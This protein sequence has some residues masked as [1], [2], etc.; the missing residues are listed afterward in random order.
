MRVKIKK[1]TKPGDQLDYSLV[2][3][4]IYGH[5]NIDSFPKDSLVKNTIKKVPRSEANIEAEGGETVL[6]PGE[7]TSNGLSQHFKVQGNRHNEGGVPLNVPDGSFVFSDTRK[8]KIKDKDTLKYFGMT[9]SSTPAKIAKKYDLN[10]YNQILND[11]DSTRIDKETAQRMITNNKA[12]LS[13]I[14]MVQEAMKGFENG[15][16][17]FA[18]NVSPDMK[19][20]GKKY[21]NGSY[22]EPYTLNP[23][24]LR[25][26]GMV[27]RG[28]HTLGTRFIEG[29]YENFVEEPK[30]K[31][32]SLNQ[33]GE[34]V[35]DIEDQL[36]NTT[37]KV[38][39]NLFLNPNPVDIS[40]GNPEDKQP[41]KKEIPKK[42]NYK[43][44]E[45]LNPNVNN[46]P[47][48][49]KDPDDF[50]KGGFKD[51]SIVGPN[52]EDFMVRVYED[53]ARVLMTKDG[54]IVNS[55]QPGSNQTTTQTR[56]QPTTPAPKPP[57]YTQSP[58]DDFLMER[59]DD[60]IKTG[61]KV[62]N[63][64]TQSRRPDGTF[65]P[66]NDFKFDYEDFKVRHGE[67]IKSLGYEPD[68][69][70]AEINNPATSE[71]ATR[72][73]QDAYNKEFEKRYGRKYFTPENGE[74]YGNDGQFG[75]ITYSAPG[76]KPKENLVPEGNPVQTPVVETEE[77]VTPE[78]DRPT[79]VNPGFDSQAQN[80]NDGWWLQD[81]AA[82]AGTMLDRV[83]TYR[84][85]RQQVTLDKVDSTFVDPTRQIAS[86]QEQ[87][88]R[89]Q[90]LAMNTADGQVARANVL[91]NSG[92]ALGATADAIANYENQNAQI[93]NQTSA[94]NAEITNQERM[95]NLELDDRYIT[96][97]ATMNQQKDNAMREL[98][99][100][101]LAAFVNGTT[102]NMKKKLM[103]QVLFPNYAIDPITFD[104]QFQ[105]SKGRS[106]TGF[107]P[108]VN[109]QM[110]AAG[111][112]DPID[113]VTMQ[114]QQALGSKKRLIEAGYSKEDAE[115]ALQ[116]MG[117]NIRPD[118]RGAN[119]LFNL[120]SMY[121]EMFSR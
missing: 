29:L 36:L 81:I 35:G 68:E 117:R 88:S 120:Q 17:S 79:V 7:G 16:P 86:I 32:E 113:M 34:K 103:D 121:N 4:N 54:R 84:P 112:S 18:E 28:L 47:K 73:F 85:K 92:Q 82:F 83:N 14:A 93:A 3:G 94:T 57:S 59:A 8:L 90:D 80:T 65:A 110:G 91:A 77:V 51:E 33:F 58:L 67:F 66:S 109:P 71:K 106:V 21:Q 75:V 116:Q 101:R 37:R 63:L 97:L 39:Y 119:N 30:R 108:Y 26:Y 115:W 24:D 72:I 27:G 12:K 52:G 19:Y 53:G 1:K 95:T 31:L 60:F 49:M 102:N 43:D 40:L 111:M 78:R 41:L 45:V 76:F 61:V 5:K 74:P 44:S 87:S 118:M 62:D 56:Q 96:Q 104:M 20:G 9:K 23:K 114:A 10:N 107:D 105:G 6:I 38:G 55:K 48:K 2:V 25:N 64:S 15:I 89:Y 22:V 13:E 69:F 98:K 50:Q 100:R 70:I 99:N 42:S 46:Q 11:P